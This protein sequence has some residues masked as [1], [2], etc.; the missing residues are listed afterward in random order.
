M[1]VAYQ[2][3]KIKL[4][5]KNATIMTQLFKSIKRYPAVQELYEDRLETFHGLRLLLAAFCCP[6]IHINHL[7]YI[8]QRY[9]TSIFHRTLY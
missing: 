4:S 8:I 1:H 6:T 9:I 5:R 7:L 2:E 3:M